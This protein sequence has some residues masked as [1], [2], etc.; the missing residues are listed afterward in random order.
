MSYPTLEQYQ[1]ALQ[2][3]GTALTD[4]MLATGSIQSTGL[5]LPL[6][7]SGGFAL[8][9]KVKVANKQFAVRCFHREAKA[10]E[11]RYDA[12]SRRLSALRSQYFLDF[13][14]QSQGVRV[15][16]KPYPL[17]RMAWAV[18]ETL[19]EFLEAS[20]GRK[21]RLAA[22]R[23]SLRKLAAFLETNGIAHGDIQPGNLMVSDEGRAVQ[24]ID[25]DGMYLPE[26][27]KLGASELGHRNFQHPRRDSQHFDAK[28]DRF[29]FIQIDVALRALE[30][31][32]SLWT[33]T[34]SEADAIL[35]RANDLVDP[36][37]SNAFQL[38]SG[39]PGLERDVQNFAGICRAGYSDVPS[40][41]DFVGGR[42]V[43]PPGPV[44]RLGGPV[45][46]LARAAYIAAFPVLDAS[47]FDLFV[48]HIG[49]KVELIGRIVEVS[50]GFTARGKGK[51]RPYIFVN[52]GDWQTQ[53]VKLSI[54][55]DALATLG[56]RPDESWVGSWVSVKGMVD[57]VYVHKVRK[58][59][60]TGITIT[61]AHQIQRLDEAEA[62]YRL[63]AKVGSSTNASASASGATPSNKERLARFGDADSKVPYRTAPSRPPSAVPQSRN[64]QQLD[65][66]RAK[67]GPTVQPPSGRT[68]PSGRSGPSTPNSGS[69]SV[70][71]YGSQSSG[72]S[73]PPA[74]KSGTLR[75]WL[76]L[77]ALVVLWAIFKKH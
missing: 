11:S 34:L 30:G 27:A 14:Y 29:A 10:L 32:S 73:R 16:G 67:M 18:G 56:A 71:G 26:L 62:K 52:F 49:Q 23:E 59:Q 31:R 2:H 13:S 19:G 57:P 65:Q 4:P 55:S 70:G 50:P 39:I 44:I 54:W 46:S 68:S 6:V 51:G 53:N 17:I 58:Y 76:G 25:Y 43:P 69:P 1:E 21:D 72:H 33:Q 74:Q 15:L 37:S 77:I 35:F 36:A 3:P 40:L 66:I 47:R 24:L 22:L 63:G 41:Q 38:V 9:Y 45:G 64:K 20:Y 28:L 8:T 7:I 12:I 75:W 5:G 61:T 48:N 42:H 60:S